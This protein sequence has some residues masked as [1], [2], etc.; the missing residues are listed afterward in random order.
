[1]AVDFAPKVQQI[2][3]QPVIG[4][5][6]GDDSMARLFEGFGKAASDAVSFLDESVKE[7]IQDEAINLFEEANKPFDP[8]GL[9]GDFAKT[10]N[11]MSSL[12]KAWE[13]GKISDTQY[14]GHLVSGTKRLKNKFPGYGKEVDAIIQGVT[15][16]RPANALRNSIMQELEAQR[17]SSDKRESDWMDF[18]ET[19]NTQ[20]ALGEAYPDIFTNPERYASDE[21]RAKVRSHVRSTTARSVSSS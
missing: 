10:Q 17:K 9:P 2:E 1:M 15:G 3:G 4:S 14:Y 13:Q 7:D 11:R 12:Q 21:A 20:K 19:Q 18:L 6:E 5:T 8:T 16:V